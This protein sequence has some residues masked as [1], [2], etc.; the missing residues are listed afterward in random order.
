MRPGVILAGLGV[1]V[2]VGN[3][4][5]A[6]AAVIIFYNLAPKCLCAVGSF[7]VSLVFYFHSKFIVNDCIMIV[8]CY[9]A[10]GYRVWLIQLVYQS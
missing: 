4:L 10:T 6:L 3:L 8:K 1:N 7:F 2:K 9:F 5:C